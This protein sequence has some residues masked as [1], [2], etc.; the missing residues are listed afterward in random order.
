MLL[1]FSEPANELFTA[2]AKA[3]GEIKQVEKDRT[4]TVQMKSGGSYSYSYATLANVIA[5]VKPAL[6]K[7]GITFIQLPKV[8][9]RFLQLTT[10]VTHS[11]D[12]TSEKTRATKVAPEA[13]I[14]LIG[15]I[16]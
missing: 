5:A 11:T 1:N 4:V 7:N 10:L 16:G 6:S 15:L 13:N 3:Q 14:S 8:G 2:L 12:F 9:D